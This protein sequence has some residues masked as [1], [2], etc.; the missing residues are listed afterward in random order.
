[1]AVT[2]SAAPAYSPAPTTGLLGLLLGNQNPVAQWAGTHSNFLG[3]L[4]AGIGSGPTIGAGL[5][6]AAQLVPQARQADNGINQTIKYL[7]D[8]GDTDLIPLVTA[9]KGDQALQQSIT[10]HAPGYG[11]QT[12]APGDI[13]RDQ[14]TGKVT[15]RAP[16]AAQPIGW[17]TQGYHDPNTGIDT[18]INYGDGSNTATTAIG[19]FGSPTIDPTIEG[20]S[21]KIVP[22]T[23]G[24]TRSA[25]DQK[26]NFYLTSG[27]PIPVG[28]GGA[29]GQQNAAIANR[30]A[31]I[32]PTGNIA[33]NKTQFGSL[34]G[35]L[36]KQ[37][38]YFDTTQ[39]S[40]ANAEA[41]FNQVIGA[42]QGKVNL[43]QYPTINAAVNAVKGQIDPGTISAFNAG[44]QEV[45]NEY[46]QVFSRGG[47]VTDSVR[48]RAQSIANGNL[49]L[50]DLQKTLD[51]LQQQ[52]SIVING[53]KDQ[54]KKI[55]DQIAGLGAQSASTPTDNKLPTPSSQ[56]DF[57]SLPKGAHYIDP[58]DGQEYVK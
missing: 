7:T 15:F 28:R 54:I 31:E 12:L 17:G 13:I 49:S 21:T 32:D 5:G 42:F 1:M 23:G 22:G 2:S 8:K 34:S 9:G 39:R 24:L 51:E 48:N 37:Q 56:Q 11:Q 41:G 52:G 30:M 25:L 40:L 33:A 14:A 18:P 43:S 36:R 19:T 47:Q 38:A 3:A 46:T 16:L 58:D 4:G 26:A 10:R 27:T 35:S 55:N 20:Y 50:P 29:Q 57:D 53:S 44:L 6:A 45:A